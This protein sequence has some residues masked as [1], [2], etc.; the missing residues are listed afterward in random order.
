MWPIKYTKMKISLISKLIVACFI[1]ATSLIASAQPGFPSSLSVNKVTENTVTLSWP[2]VSGVYGYHIAFKRG[3][4]PSSNP[5]DNDCGYLDIV[6][7]NTLT[8]QV[9]GLASNT[10]YSFTIFGYSQSIHHVKTYS[11]SSTDT[12]AT[13]LVK[14]TIELDF[15]QGASL[16]IGRPSVEYQSNDYWAKT[17]SNTLLYHPKGVFVLPKTVGLSPSN[18]NGTMFIADA[19]NNRVLVYN[20]PPENYDSPADII[21]G[22][23]DSTAGS[24]GNTSTN[25]NSPSGVHAVIIDNTTYLFV[26]DQMNNR[27]L[28]FNNIANNSTAWKV[29]GQPNFTSK[30]AA[31]TQSG[32][33]NPVAITVYDKKLIVADEGNNRVMIWNNFI[34]ALT[35]AGA[36]V[37][38]GQMDFISRNS[39]DQCSGNSTAATL[40]SPYGVAVN[41][42]Q[43]LVVASRLEH[44]ILIY[45]SIPTGN[46]TNANLVLGQNNFNDNC[47]TN[48]AATSS[49]MGFLRGVSISSVFDNTEKLSV[50]DIGNRRVMVWNTFP[51]TNNQAAQVI[52][53]KPSLTANNS[54]TFSNITEYNAHTMGWC[55]YSCFAPNGDFYLSDNYYSHIKRFDKAAGNIINPSDITVTA[56]TANSISISWT[57]NTRHYKLAYALKGTPDNEYTVIDSLAA[58]AYTITGLDC[59]ALYSIRV[60]G[61]LLAPLRYANGIPIAKEVATSLSTTCSNKAPVTNGTVRTIAAHGNIIYFGGNFTEVGGM[62]RN[63][64]AAIDATTYE[65]LPFN[66]NV[67]G[68]I[69]TMKLSANGDY[70]YVGGSFTKIGNVDLNYLSKINTSTGIAVS[71]FPSVDAQVE[72]FAMNYGSN[73]LFFYGP[74]AQVGNET[75][76]YGIAGI[77]END[78]IITS[79]KPYCSNPAQLRGIAASPNNQYVYLGHGNATITY[80]TVN[81]VERSNF[82]ELKVSDGKVTTFAPE[83]DNG[84]FDIICTNSALYFGGGFDKIEGFSNADRWK[85]AKF[86]G[87]PGNWTLLDTLFAPKTIQQGVGNIEGGDI[88]STTIRGIWLSGNKIFACGLIHSI[89]NF[90]RYNI[91]AVDTTNATIDTNFNLG[92]NDNSDN[93]QTLLTGSSNQ[94]KIFIGTSGN[95]P[96]YIGAKPFYG[97]FFMASTNINS[98][99]YGTNKRITMDGTYDFESSRTGIMLNFTGN[100]IPGIITVERYID[101]PINTWKITETNI[102]NYRFVIHRKEETRPNFTSVTVTF[103]LNNIPNHGITDPSKVK[104]YRRSTFGYSAFASAG[105][106][107]YNSTNNELSVTV[108]ELGEFVFASNENDLHFTLSNQNSM[109][110]DKSSVNTFQNRYSTSIQQNEESQPL[111]TVYP[112]PSQSTFQFQMETLTNTPLEIMIYNIEGQLVETILKTNLNSFSFGKEYSAGMYLMCIKQANTSKVIKLIKSN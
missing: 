92:I 3:P 38:V 91:V 22:Q 28:V 94:N 88:K 31:C 68:T 58:N 93:A 32:L 7:E 34:T 102:S 78:Q 48:G 14:N 72:R 40:S 50:I 47:Y 63:N 83:P 37:V 43:K 96:T 4:L 95:A 30:T 13:T 112:N 11:N 8:H 75:G 55:E 15:E 53:N 51:T 46:G 111:Y 6:G 65:L 39:P 69:S 98:V 85:M 27:I 99:A 10:L 49:N 100:S 41:S 67:N 66:P 71:T 81:G 109:L 101:K 23:P 57:G 35:G 80:N 36:D 5:T 74:F 42:Q 16:A 90:A 24:P 17:T 52:L 104:I 56:R 76:Y 97:S 20:T 70:L 45:N 103:K 18:E 82:A 64:L 1:L 29:F 61:M 9:T 33:K 79:F 89:G 60:F 84:V 107:T 12:S 62:S 87:Q 106:V 86:K 44:R 2:K 73:H 25:F 21:I 77:D 105:T 59:N 19:D 26:C 54:T 108:A 110:K